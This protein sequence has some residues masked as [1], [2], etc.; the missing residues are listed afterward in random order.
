MRVLAID[1]STHAGWALLEG[2]PGDLKPQ[3]VAQ[4]LI[5][6]S[7]PIQ[8]YGD[9]PACYLAATA[10]I[11]ERLSELVKAYDPN[12]VVVE[13]VNLGKSRYAQRALEWIHCQLMEMLLP[14]GWSVVYISSSSW[15]QALGLVMSKEDKKNNSKLSKARKIAA[16]TAMSIHEAKKRVGVR[17]RINKKHLAVRFVNELY[18]LNFKVKDNDRAD[19]ICL[20]LAYLRG[21]EPADGV[22]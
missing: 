16:S 12:V 20:G 11:V 10:A 3:L 21:A 4:G 2:E 19:A 15:R 9:Y 1:A 17:G 6:N 22:L 8:A 18:G 13:E 5:E 7:Q 14:L